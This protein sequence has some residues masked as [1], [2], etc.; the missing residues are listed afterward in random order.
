MM[1]VLAAISALSTD[2]C[3][4]MFIAVKIEVRARVVSRPCDAV[5]LFRIRSSDVEAKRIPKPIWTGHIAKKPSRSARDW[6]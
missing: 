5:L 6:T 4:A 2:I 3:L 1:T